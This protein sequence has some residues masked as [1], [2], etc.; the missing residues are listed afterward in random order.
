M[1]IKAYG[2]RAG[3]LPLEP[4]AIMRRTPGEHDVQIDIAYCGV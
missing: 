4:L 3:N 1:T 2:A